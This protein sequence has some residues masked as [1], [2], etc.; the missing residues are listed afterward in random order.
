MH[1]WASGI[2][3]CSASY[4]TFWPILNYACEVWAVNPSVG[5]AAELLYRGFPSH[6]LCVR[7]SAANKTVLAEFGRFLLQIFRYHLRIVASDS[8]RHVKLAMVSGCTLRADQSVTAATNKSWQCHVGS[9][10]L[11][12]AIT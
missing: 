4:L 2:Q 11:H 8:I 12:A 9:V 7:M 6:L 5:E 10:S 3:L 1:S